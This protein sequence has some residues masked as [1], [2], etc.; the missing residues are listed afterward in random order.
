MAKYTKG[1]IVFFQGRWRCRVIADNG[2]SV[3]YVA[4]EGVP[5]GYADETLN[6][7]K[8]LFSANRNTAWGA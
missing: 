4:L 2:A 3:A 1:Q 7:A 6:A 5:P 8:D